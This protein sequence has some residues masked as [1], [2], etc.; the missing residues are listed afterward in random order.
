MA[1][2][3]THDPGGKSWIDAANDPAGDFPIQNLPFGI[4]RRAGT[5]EPL[6]GG[7]AVGD[8]VLDLGALHAAGLLRGA[9]GEA[10]SAA[11]A[12]SLNAVMA[13]GPDRRVALRQA[14]F[15]LLA[16]GGDDTSLR[17][18]AASMLVPMAAAELGLP[19]AIGDYSDFYASIHHATNVGRLLRPDAPL[20]PNYKWL[21]VG[22]HGRASTVVAS[23][24]PVI[25][26]NGQTRPR[27]AEQP[28]FGPSRRLDF[29]LELGIFTAAAHRMGEPI[30]IADAPRHIFGYCLLNDWS[31]R[32]IQGWEYQP[33]GPFLAKSFCTTIS[34][35]VVTAEALAPFRAPVAARPDGDP[36]PLPHL[37][38]PA[39]QAAGA[40]AI[41]L[42]V[43]LATPRMRAAGQTGFRLARSDARHLYWTPAQMVTHHASNGCWIKAGDLLG[44]GT[45]SGPDAGSLGSLLEMTEGGRK[46]LALPDGETRTFL[47]DGD[48]VTLR[49]RCE[50]EGFAPIGFGE[51]RGTIAPAHPVP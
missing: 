12:P 42:D 17:T 39:D 33:L 2:D 21:P 36:P 1:L 22:Y 13:L 45:I 47:E 30:A 20:M 7:V 50:R 48:E 15:R 41:R 19:A 31:A 8:C 37:S 24:T 23:G 43:L 10:L 35:W 9:A 34:P 3:E 4:F 32:D 16:W 38:S 11:A 46:P 40:L 49:G 29:E 18:R 5:N 28:G 25:R 14:L 6:R 44:S 27:D 26:P 51:C